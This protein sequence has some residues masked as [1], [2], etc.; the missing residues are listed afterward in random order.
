VFSERR[1]EM[2]LTSGR[3]DESVFLEMNESYIEEKNLAMA[4]SPLL[5]SMKD[6]KAPVTKTPFQDSRWMNLR[7]V[8]NFSE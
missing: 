6:K 7:D 5:L 8:R 4:L 1:S 2:T 3:D